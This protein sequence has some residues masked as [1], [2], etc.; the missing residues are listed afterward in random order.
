MC[1]R[2]S[3]SI[4]PTYFFLFLV[5]WKPSANRKQNNGNA[6]VPM[7][8]KSN[9]MKLSICWNCSHDIWDVY[10]RQRSASGLSGLSCR[11]SC[12]IRRSASRQRQAARH[13][14]GKRLWCCLLY[15]SPS[16]AVVSEINPPAPLITFWQT[17]NTAMVI[18]KQLVICLLYTS[19]CV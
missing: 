13:W 11:R 16:I 4:N 14:R 19:R 15:T 2:D 10:K 12:R 9:R 8:C 18:L 1:I 3:T 17:S 6:I 7:L 5:C